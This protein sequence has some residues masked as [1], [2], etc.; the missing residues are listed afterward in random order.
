MS[1]V[2]GTLA[3]A[4]G[5]ACSRSSRVSGF[6][7]QGHAQNLCSS[8]KSKGAAC[9]VRTAA[10]AQERQVDQ[11]DVDALILDRLGC[12]CDF[13]Q[14]ARGLFRIA[15]RRWLDVSHA[16]LRRGRAGKQIP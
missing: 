3:S 12:V 7:S 4:T 13:D 5:S 11:F 9:F 14:L 15:E 1:A 6:A 10:G 2:I 16:A 8:L